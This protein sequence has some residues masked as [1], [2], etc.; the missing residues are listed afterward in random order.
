MLLNLT[1]AKEYMKEA[2]V[3]LLVAT[4]PVNVAYLTGFDC[5]SYRTFKEYMMAGGQSNRFLKS[6][7]L[8]ALDGRPA[9]VTS[10]SNVSWTFGL[11]LQLFPYGASLV[12]TNPDRPT[13]R[14]RR[15][16]KLLEAQLRP[17]EKY[18]I[19]GLVSAIKSLGLD[20][21]TLGLE[22]DTMDEESIARIRKGLP[23]AKVGDATETLRLIRMVKTPEEIWLM[24][25]AAD[26]N[27][28]ALSSCMKVLKP[29]NAMGQGQGLIPNVSRRD[30]SVP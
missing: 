3:D 19:E 9:L 20:E 7:G 8:L 26:A 16:A 10:A 30:A 28:H 27:E 24:R 25:K 1:R 4:S 13:P 12:V 18:S 15:F 11:D 5:F 22:F 2:G 6:F 29:G 14:D 23:K 21:M 17:M